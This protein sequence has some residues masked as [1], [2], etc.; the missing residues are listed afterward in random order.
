MPICM[1]SGWR[2][3]IEWP[4]SSLIRFIMIIIC[5]PT[6]SSSGCPAQKVDSLIKDTRFCKTERPQIP[7]QQSNSPLI[8]MPQTLSQQT[9]TNAA[10]PPS[11]EAITIS[12]TRKMIGSFSRNTSTS[13]PD[14]S[15]IIL[16]SN[17]LKVRLSSE[18][19]L[20]LVPRYLNLLNLFSTVFFLILYTIVVNTPNEA[21][22]IDFAE[23]LLFAFVFGF[24]FDEVSRMSFV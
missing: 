21:G 11:G 16:I 8:F 19:N 4:N 23:G 22:E 5:S 7:S 24:F 10:S 15:R 9:I 18:D 6:S 12:N 2:P 14:D 3:A 13:I 17:V 1:L 20:R